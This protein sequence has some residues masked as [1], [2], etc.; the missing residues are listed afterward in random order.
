MMKRR[1][2]LKTGLVLPFAMALGRTS[3]AAQPPLPMVLWHSEARPNRIKAIQDLCEAFNRSQTLIH[4]TPENQDYGNIYMKITAAIQAG[5]PPDM[6]FTT[7]DITMLVQS[8]GGTIQ[9][10][11][12]EVAKLSQMYRISPSTLRPFT[13]DGKYW[14]VPLYNMAEVLWYRTDLFQKAGLDPSKPP[15]T[16]SA[17]MSTAQTLVSKSVVRFPM[18][19]AGDWAL[20]TMQQVYPL[21]CTTKAEDLFDS[22]GNVVFD[23]PNT[24]RAY[25]MYMKLFRMSPP[26]SETWQWDQ[27]LNALIAGE[28]AMVIEKGQYIEQW[29]LRTNQAPELLGAGPVPI[30]DSGG[31]H[32]TATWD[33]GILLLNASPQGRVGFDAFLDYLY[34]PETMA[35]LLGVGPGLFL[36]VTQESAR[37]KGLHDNST[38]NRHFAAY[39]VEIQ[40]SR[41]GRQLGFTK[42]PYN[43]NIGRIT[44]QNLL[45]W[46]VQQ[47]IHQGLSPEAAVKAGQQKIL[48]TLT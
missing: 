24:V 33:N 36:P 42:Q 21:M 45:A 18:G 39:S 19:V 14:S 43:K 28:I 40:E 6:L 7:P 17:L 31:Q 30:P 27:P 16:W 37:A 35:M 46:V 22:K 12:A 8:A 13:W 3:D 48:E 34:K 4:I 9:S 25:D 1:A 47:M 41:F 20:A 5:R 38:I 23:N 26:G 2:F 29:D 32:A 44:G 15:R 10:V 11:S